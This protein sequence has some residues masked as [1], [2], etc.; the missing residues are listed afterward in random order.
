MGGR[1]K[2]KKIWKI[3]N[4]GWTGNI[5][6]AFLGLI[7]AFLFYNVIL[8]TALGTKTPVVAVVSSSM[9]HDNPEVTHYKWL[10]EHFN[11]SREFIDSWPFP[12]GLNVGDMPIV[13]GCDKYEVGDIIVYK[14]PGQPAPIIHRIVKINED[15]TYQTKGDNNLVQLPYEYRVKKSQIY[16]KVIFVI[17]KLG[18]VKVALVKI[19]GIW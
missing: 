11:Y 16:G 7:F 9:Q 5:F 12:N 15:G 19:L 17:P 14:V 3:L 2:L 8:S 13:K 6:Y 1:K 4:E 18:W 10:M